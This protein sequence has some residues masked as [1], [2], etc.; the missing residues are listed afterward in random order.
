MSGLD[1][2]LGFHKSAAASACKRQCHPTDQI[3][4]ICKKFAE[5]ESAKELFGALSSRMIADACPA[6]CL[7]GEPAMRGPDDNS[8]EWNPD[9]PGESSALVAP[10]GR[11]GSLYENND[12]PVCF[13]ANELVISAPTFPPNQPFCA[14]NAIAADAAAANSVAL[15]HVAG[16]V[17]KHCY[18]RPPLNGRKRVGDD[19]TRLATRGR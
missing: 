12:S 14:R 16:A 7:P 6:N 19:R 10:I 8:P 2:W 15:G 13:L 4:R 9:E 11:G 3:E 5:F 18:L 17:G 1:G